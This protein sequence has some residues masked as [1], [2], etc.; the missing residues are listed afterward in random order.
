V[1]LEGLFDRYD[2]EG[3]GRLNYKWFADA[4]LGV[5]ANPEATPGVRAALR[6]ARAAMAAEGGR[7]GLKLLQVRRALSALAAARGSDLV[8]RREAQRVLLQ[9]VPR[10][11]PWDLQEVLAEACRPHAVGGTGGNASEGSLRVSELLVMLRGAIGRGRRAAV[12]AAWARIDPNRLGRAQLADVTAGAG[13]PAAAF[14]PLL[15]GHPSS[16]VGQAAFV[17]LYRDMS[18]CVEED[19][20][21]F[22]MLRASFPSSP[23][24]KRAAAAGLRR[25]A[26]SYSS[27]E[28]ASK[29]ATAS[30]EA[31]LH[32]LSEHPDAMHLDEH[33]AAAALQ[34]LLEEHKATLEHGHGHA[35]DSQLQSAINT[36]LA[37]LKAGVAA[38]VKEHDLE[39][40][41]E[42]EI[43][44]AASRAAAKRPVS[45]GA[46]PS[47]AGVAAARAAAAA[48][49]ELQEEEEAEQ[50]AEAAMRAPKALPGSTRAVFRDI[51]A[52]IVPVPYEGGGAEATVVGAV[53][54]QTLYRAVPRV[55]REW[56]LGNN[57][58]VLQMPR[59]PEP[60]GAGHPSVTRIG[61]TLVRGVIAELEPPSA[62]LEDAAR[63]AAAAAGLPQERAHLLA[64]TAGGRAALNYLE[65][66]GRKGVPVF[67]FGKQTSIF[68]S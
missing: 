14:L 17:A 37:R 28:L 45:S 43:L 5:V 56:F 20:D 7:T 48:A 44:A 3:T 58:R 27:S 2:Y 10:L 39:L 41:H 65:S 24:R 1:K 8:P 38:A 26:A 55:G 46:G 62:A 33:P 61:G 34:R 16:V 29:N 50:A 54:G 66:K 47:G 67:R 21:F 32:A 42:A 25:D 49:R 23:A 60:F 59:A 68:G 57:S 64:A 35:Y 40:A 18:A 12:D 51:A 9:E 11:R 13:Q 31:A 19:E 6:L 63:T 4:L 36:S 22:G 52:G 30:A 15:A 53:F